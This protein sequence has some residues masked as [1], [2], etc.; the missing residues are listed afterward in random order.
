MAGGTPDAVDG[1][2]VA[3]VA[4]AGDGCD[5][6]RDAV[7]TCGLWRPCS[8]PLLVARTTCSGGT[9]GLK[10]IGDGQFNWITNSYF[11][12]MFGIIY[13]NDCEYDE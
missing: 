3:A 7:L 13:E 9:V 6:D 5:D 4:G 12:Q 10:F 2:T 11:L 1:T 8:G